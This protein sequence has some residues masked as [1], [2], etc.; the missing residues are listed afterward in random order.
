ME[1]GGSRRDGRSESTAS[2]GLTVRMLASISDSAAA[3]LPCNATISISHTQLPNNDYTI[4]ISTTRQQVL[5]TSPLRPINRTSKRKRDFRYL[6][7]G[8]GNEQFSV[9]SCPCSATAPALTGLRGHNRGARL[10]E[11]S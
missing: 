3:M 5:Y 1:C 2:S 7:V 10:R 11:S 9:D 4:A 8:T 6:L